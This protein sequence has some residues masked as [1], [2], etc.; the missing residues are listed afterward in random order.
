MAHGFSRAEAVP[1][2]LI[3]LSC[4]MTMSGAPVGIGDA[5]AAAAA[6]GCAADV[7][8]VDPTPGKLGIDGMLGMLGMLQATTTDPTAVSASR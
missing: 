8:F 5:A 2:T 3:Q 6:V 7:V 1:S 4:V